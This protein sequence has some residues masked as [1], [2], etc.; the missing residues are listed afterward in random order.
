MWKKSGGKPGLRTAAVG[1]AI[2]FL[3]APVPGWAQSYV[4]TTVA[5]G[6]APYPGNGDGGPATSAN[7]GFPND[8]A[9]DQN[10]NLFIATGV[11]RKVTPGGI[12]STYAG[13]AGA[14]ESGD[15]GPATQAGLSA[16]AIAVDP[17]GNLYIADAAVLGST[18]IRKVNLQGII[19][20][21]SG[22]SQINAHVL[23]LAADG[24][25]NVYMVDDSGLLRKLDTNGALSILAGQGSSS[26]SG[27]PATDASFGYPSGVAVDSAGNLYVADGNLNLVRKISASNG[28]INTIAGNGTATYSGDGSPATEAGIASAWH[29]A[30]DS[31]G[32][33]YFTERLDGFAQSSGNYVRMVTPGGTITTIA[34]NGNNGFGGDGGS[35]TM[36][37]FDD[38]LGIAAGAGGA[39][40]VADEQNNRI[41]LLTPSGSAS[42]SGLTISSVVNAFS[43]SPTIAPNTWVAVKGS[44]LA[45]AGDSRTWQGSDFVN[46]QLPTNLDGVSVT[47]N[48]EPAYIYYISGTQLNVLTPPDLALGAVQVQ[49]AVNGTTSSTFTTPSQA[50]SLSF[51]VFDTAG[52]VVGTHLNGNDL[53]PASLYPGLTTPTQPGEEVVLYANGFGPVSSQV[54]KGSETQSGSLPTLPVITIGGT[55][56]NVLFAGLVEPGL[57]QF[58]VI[59]PQSAASGDNA[60]SATYNGL[61]T[62]SP[63]LLTI[64]SNNAPTVQSVTF[65]AAS[66]ASGGTA[67]GTV[68]ISATAPSGGIVVALSSNSSAVTVPSTV[69]VASGLTS[70]T[71]AVNAGAVN[72]TT[73]VIITASYQGS[74]AQAAIA[75]TPVSGTPPKVQSVTLGSGSVASGGTVQGTVTLS[76]PAPTAAVMVALTSSSSAATVPAS[77][78]VSP[79]AISA[80]FT[81]TAS[82]VSATTSVTITAS[83]QSSS[84][85]ATLSVTAAAGGG[86]SLPQFSVIVIYP[87]YS[88][89]GQAMTV[90]D[91]EI[92]NVTGGAG[93]SD[94]VM[95]GAGTLSSGAVSFVASFNTIS[96]TGYTFTLGGLQLGSSSYMETI[97]GSLYGITAGSV[98]VTLTPNGAPGVGSVTGTFSVTSSFTTLKGTIS[99]SY[100]AN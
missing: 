43:N 90:G 78:I 24:A 80:T 82:T 9:V 4:I 28:V 70:A 60:L 85:Q 81:I 65:S 19:N 88:I 21:L 16:E 99:G 95:E 53:G 72:T 22:G 46:G 93:Y 51:F 35:A 27:V 83:Y 52:Y 63:V 94:A 58:N 2:A 56:A 13:L 73:A 25:G 96:Q 61:T 87:T 11:V 6:G 31:A 5:G 86:G 17:A 15:G 97:A 18:R 66:V 92:F 55:Q 30:V 14:S 57:Y 38:P 47:M 44:N 33:V 100:L 68:I 75:V 29:V 10:G 59:V 76:S 12:I 62:Q 37:L 45:P 49:V 23:G 50:E 40:Y 7:I 34:G 98:T 36:A 42:G 79:G 3:L 54:V 69:T 71:F 8:V 39:V 26:L 84:A 67:Q 1:V 89:T 48:G 20:T 41:R 64:H 91:I 32:N 77:V 74:S